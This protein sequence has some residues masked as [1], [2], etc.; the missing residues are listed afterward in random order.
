MKPGRRRLTY[1]QFVECARKKHAGRYDYP[2]LGIMEGS[3]S[4][5]VIICREH[6]K[7][8]QI[9]ANHLA[10]NGCPKCGRIAAGEAP[11]RAH[12][13]IPRDTPLHQE[14]FGA[15]GGLYKLPFWS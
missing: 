5:L 9:A 12:R 13:R 4:K 7:F 14:P 3:R 1:E 10:G 2:E 8:T 15:L 6:G 11:R